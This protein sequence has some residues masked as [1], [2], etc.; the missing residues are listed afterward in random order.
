MISFRYHLV[1]IVAVFLAIALGVLMGTTLVNQGVIDDLGRRTNAAVDRIDGL[2]DQVNDLSTQVQA[3]ESF[4]TAVQPL[5]VEGELVGREVVIVT[6]EGVDVAEV[7]DVRRILQ[8]SGGDVVG[9]L[10]VRPRM[11]LPDETGR[12]ELATL[13]GSS[14]S[15]P[16]EQLETEAA[17][18]LGARLALGAGSGDED[19]LEQ[20]VSADFL[21][22]RGGQGSP[23]TVGGSDQG[24]VLLSGGETEPPVTPEAFLAP[25]AASLVE[26]SRPV[27]AAETSETTYPFVPLVRDNGSLDGDMATVDNADTMPGRIALVLALRDLFLRPGSGGDYG[28]KDGAATLLPTP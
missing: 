25:L 18:E 9:V 22:L 11:A 19:F 12:G 4:G 2:R 27:V 20:L 7:E 10:V 17:E 5:L 24:V 23:G 1:T 3:W 26:F 14:A 8:E 16:P 13:L 28:I 15:K 21:A 6:L